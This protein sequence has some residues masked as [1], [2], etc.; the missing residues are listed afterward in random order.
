MA[1]NKLQKIAE[2]GKDLHKLIPKMV[3]EKGQEFAAEALGVKQPTISKW[4]K[5]NGYVLRTEWVKEGDG[6]E[7][8]AS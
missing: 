8:I 6:K 2:Q 3:N 4:L 5:D 7:P 1:N